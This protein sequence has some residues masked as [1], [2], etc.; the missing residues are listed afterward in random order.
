MMICGALAGSNWL[1]VWGDISTLGLLAWIFKQTGKFERSAVVP[2]S[3]ISIGLPHLCRD[4]LVD[5]EKSKLCVRGLESRER[6]VQIHE[7]LLQGL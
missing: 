6:V 2:I 7:K 5:C 3:K 1:L 4:T